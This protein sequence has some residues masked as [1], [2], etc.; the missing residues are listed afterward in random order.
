VRDLEPLDA[1]SEAVKLARSEARLRTIAQL[2][3]DRV[4]RTFAF[5]E[6]TVVG[7]RLKRAAGRTRRLAILV[8]RAETAQQMRA[9]AEHLS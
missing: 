7:S 4:V 1:L 6:A 9:L 2:D 5:A 3:L 8:A